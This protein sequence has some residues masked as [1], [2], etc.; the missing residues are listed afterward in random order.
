M[1]K[2][3]ETGTKEHGEVSKVK[4]QYMHVKVKMKTQYFIELML[5]NKL[6]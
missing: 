5:T 2:A 6:I 1:K 3:S 4:V